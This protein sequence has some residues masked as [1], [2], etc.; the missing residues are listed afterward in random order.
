MISHTF[1]TDNLIIGGSLESLLYSYVT[2]TPIIIENPHRPC[3]IEE[4]HSSLDFSFLGFA[5]HEKVVSL[6]LW[7]RLSFLLSLS[8][9]LMFPNS[10]ENITEEEGRLIV[11]THNMRRVEVTFNK[12][13]K[14]DLKFTNFAWI[15]DWFAVRSGGRHNIDLLEDEEYLAGK[16]IFYPSNRVGVRNSK[17][18][19]AVTYLNVD[20]IY[21]MEYSE[22]YVSLKTRMMMKEAGI[23][24]TSKGYNKLRERTFEPIRIEHLAREIKKQIIPDMTVGQI[25]E[26]PRKT[27]GKLWKMTES[28]F[29]RGALFT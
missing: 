22:G 17:D 27:K 24:G 18:V 5:E 15:Y 2:E 11:A 26:Q 9:L 6:R 13:R 16:L 19:I 3:E 4:M 29:K 28:L 8:G 1:L 25:L 20:N 7:E 21:D 14:F 12:L 23:R 10:I